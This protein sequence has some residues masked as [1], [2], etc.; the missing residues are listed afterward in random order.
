MRVLQVSKAVYYARY[1]VLATAFNRPQM[2]A[3]TSK[4]RDVA[5]NETHNLQIPKKCGQPRRL[6]VFRLSRCR[7]ARVYAD[8]SNVL[9]FRR[10]IPRGDE[11]GLPFETERTHDGFYYGGGWRLLLENETKT[12][13]SDLEDEFEINWSEM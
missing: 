10:F 12:I 13:G 1:V 3:V 11:V 5:N 9:R 2:N 6:D 8:G 4:M 7:R